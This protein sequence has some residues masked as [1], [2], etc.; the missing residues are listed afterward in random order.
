MNA[1]SFSRAVALSGALATLLIA[2][3]VSNAQEESIEEITVTGSHIR[4]DTFTS[5]SPISVVDAGDIE[6]VGAVNTADLLARLPS[7]VGEANGSSRNVNEPQSSGLNT[8]ALRNLGASR[9]LVLVNGRRYVSGTSAGHG[10]GVDLNTIP[11]TMIER[12]EV[13]TG[14][15]SAAYGSDAV[16]GVVNIITKKDFE[17]I[18]FKTQFGSSSEGSRDKTDV[19]FTVGRNFSDNGNA[20]FS[21]G[22]SDDDGLM[23]ADRDFS[24]VHKSAVDTDADGIQDSLE[25]V[26]SSHILSGRIGGYKGDGTAFVRTFDVDTSD[27]FNFHEFRSLVVPFERRFAAAGLSFDINDR[28][29]ASFEANWARVESRARFE[30][31]PLDTRN[32]IFELSRGGTTGMNIDPV[33][34]A[35]HPLFDGTD[36]QTSL[37]NDGI[38][39]ID[40]VS[41][42]FRRLIEFGDRGSGNTRNTFR[43]AAAVDHEFENGMYLNVYG[44]YGITDQ[45]QTDFGD[46]NLER[47][48]FALDMEQDGFGGWQCIDEIARID[49]CVPFNP[50][51]I[52]GNPN[53]DPL[54]VGITPEAVDYLAAAV[55]LEGTVEHVVVA[56]VLSG[57]LP[58]SIGDNDNLA[59]ATGIEYREEKGRETPDGLRQKGITRGFQLF[60]TRGNFNVVE[61]FGE[62][63]VPLMEQLI[64]DLA[65]RTGDYSSVG[66]TT[67]WKVGLDAPINDWLRLRAAQSTSNRSPNVSDLF[68]GGTATA[69]IVDDPCNG[70]DDATTGNAAENCR[71]IAA[72]QN[73][74]DTQGAFILTQVESQNT[75]GILS[76]SELVGEEEADSTTIGAVFT[77]PGLEGFSLA[78]DYYD[79]EIDDAIAQTDRTVILNRCHNVSPS[80]FDPNCGGLVRRDLNSGAA[81]EVNSSTN[82]ENIIETS[83]IDLEASY[84][85]DLGPG[86]IQVSLIA[87]FLS[88]FKVTGIETGD[89]EDLDGEVEFPD[90]RFNLS[91]SYT[92]SDFNVYWQMRYWDETK[93]RNI[94]P[95]DVS[96][97]L[98]DVDS[99]TYHDLRASYYINDNVNVYLGANNLFDEDPP[100]L[101]A[102]QKYQQQGTIS[103]GTA[104]DL[105]GRQW[106][107]GISASFE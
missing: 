47:A 58:F 36:L 85:S 24:R 104:F 2:P 13:L 46:I 19:E 44:T 18:A 62:L 40:D 12:I 17:G 33:L 35:V 75:S 49:G 63:Q 90:L 67:T 56:S 8:I 71:S 98:N 32:N 21:F 10:Y 79:I 74:I 65:V 15:Q 83:G 27:A 9:T 61:V 51:N 4:K 72:I 87:N 64:L 54:G 31:I 97:G 103:N 68:A 59:F 99:V 100:L 45:V 25:F 22:Y 57:D 28:T 23:D 89:T 38:Q 94:R 48:R 93:D 43:I 81:L 14:G 76:G 70:V 6:G 26:G 39:N 96:D 82:N 29:T 78:L 34:G 16:A 92:W 42:T 101:G 30:P 53:Q 1:K 77:P 102:N 73:R 105:T 3:Q 50:F 107:A 20:W 80:E 91:T 69:A 5:S 106:Y 11:T 55:G 84:A 88:E 95:A 86:D 37:L 7:V 60:P 52:G 41:L 66:S